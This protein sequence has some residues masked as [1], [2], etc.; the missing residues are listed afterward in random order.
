MTRSAL[1]PSVGTEREVRDIMT[2]GV[3]SIPTDASMRRVHETMV[4]HGVH[5]VLVID[6]DSGLPVGWVTARGLLRWAGHVSRAHTAKQAI[7]EPI[8]IISPSASVGDAIA[9]LLEADV[10]HLLVGR[11]N[12]AVPEGV[13]ADIDIVRHDVRA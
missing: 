7:N 10:S 1:A 12:S 11:R 13:V 6:R 2:S 3:V 8:H 4:A 9:M 5:A